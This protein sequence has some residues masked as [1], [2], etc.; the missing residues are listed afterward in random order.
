MK[1]GNLYILIFFFIG[2]ISCTHQ[3]AENQPNLVFVFADQWRA[4]DVGYAGNKQVHTP[5]ID[6]LVSEGVVFT[7]AISNCPVCSPAR[8][9]LMTG[10]YPLTHGVFYNDKPLSTDAL[11]LAEVYK[12][13]GYQTAYI[14]KWH[15]NGRDN[16]TT[17]TESR[18]EPVQKERRQGFDYWRAFE[19]THDYNNSYYYD[20]NNVRHKWE[21]YDALAQTKEAISYIKNNKEN[22]FVLFLSWGPPHAPYQTAPK[23]YQKLF[24]DVDIEVRPNVPDSLVEQT[25]SWLRG[26]Y[27]HIAALDD[28]VGQ[29]QKAIKEEG[30]DE[31]TIFVFTSDHGDMLNSH[32]QLKKQKPW[33]ESI[34]IPFIL[35]YPSELKPGTINK[36]F[37]YPDIMPTLLELSDLT[38][39]ETVEGISFSGELLGKEDLQIDGGF[40]LCPVPF[41]QW[42]YK[43]GG[44]EYRGI[45]TQRYTYVV[46]LNGP[47]LLYDNQTDPYQ[48]NNLCNNQDF[49]KIQFDLDNKLQKMLDERKD[50]FLDGHS[51]MKAWNY[52]WDN[53]D[54]LRFQN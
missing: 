39:P 40:I 10:Q 29:L 49:T 14:G 45:R 3:N 48:L 44:R 47:W 23:E 1:S 2:F 31:N 34:S 36:V 33:E 54:S 18:E 8:A 22:P 51:Y 21:G 35:K 16:N 32:G 46:D 50:N 19:C 37:S 26:Y 52:A 24:E 7:N 4:Q 41:H 20:E 43:N 9:S 53:D 42:S 13:N 28:C 25:I 30:L 12:Q 15:I 6:V 27:A 11:C 5:N 38:I 17:T